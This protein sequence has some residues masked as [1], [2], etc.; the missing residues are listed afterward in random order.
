MAGLFGLDVAQERAQDGNHLVRVVAEAE[1]GEVDAVDRAVI[2]GAVETVGG[3]IVEVV[4]VLGL[5]ALVVAAEGGILLGKVSAEERVLTAVG[6]HRTLE[7]YDGNLGACLAENVDEVVGQGVAHHL[8][9]VGY[10]VDEVEV[11]VGNRGHGAGHALIHLALAG[12]ADVDDLAV[13]FA[14]DDVGGGHA[15]ARGAATLE[16]RG[17]VGDDLPIRL[18]EVDASRCD[19]RAGVNL[20]K[21]FVD[22][23]VEG[24]VDHVLVHLAVEV[25]D[26]GRLDLAGLV[27]VGVLLHVGTVG[28]DMAPYGVTLE[29]IEVG[30]LES[31]VGHVDEVSVPEKFV[32]HADA[33]GVGGEA[34]GNARGALRALPEVGADGILEVGGNARV[35]AKG[36]IPTFI[37]NAKVAGV[38]IAP[39]F[40][41]GVGGKKVG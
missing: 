12:D 15:G 10:G 37:N 13:E 38:D 11:G 8:G 21:E 28:V 2:L 9:A 17:A 40:L 34:D 29:G 18:D 5:Q 22:A 31:G 1:V 14:G 41:G 3:D 4:G 35:G 33:L 39:G 24:E 25:L 6:V 23:V 16:D 30:T 27:A 36:V 32:F 26:I 19:D 20:D 7:H